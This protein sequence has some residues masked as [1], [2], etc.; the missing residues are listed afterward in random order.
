[1]SGVNRYH[2]YHPHIAGRDVILACDYDAQTV[3]LE[4]AKSHCDQ[5]M[6]LHDKMEA[7]RNAIQV[8]LA[9]HAQLLGQA[10]GECIFAAKIIRPNVSLTGPELLMF[11]QDLKIHLESIQ[12][13]HIDEQSELG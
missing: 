9:H 7:E 4:N 3:L 1:M 12:Q 10:L 11:A 8:E 5:W 2:P 6:S 13:E